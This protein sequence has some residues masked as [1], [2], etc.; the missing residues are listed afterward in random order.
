MEIRPH[1]TQLFG[2]LLVVIFVTVAAMVAAVFIAGQRPVVVVLPGTPNESPPPVLAAT[3]GPTAVASPVGATPPGPD[4]VAAPEPPT[5]RVSRLPAAPGIGNPF[6][7]A[8]DRVPTVELPLQPQQTAPPMLAT[9][10]IATVRVQAARDDRRIVWRLSWGQEEPAREV[11]VSTFSDA[12]AVQ[13]PMV[14]GAPFTMGGPGMPVRVL[15]WRA[16]WQQDLDA[17]FQDV[18]SRHPNTWNDLYWFAEGPP[19]HHFPAAF[20]DERA[21]DWLVAYRAGNPMA[22]FER[23]HPVEELVAEGFGSLTHVHD[24][25]SQARGAWQAGRWTVVID[26]PFD[27][28]DPLIERLGASSA[29]VSLAVWD[30]GH[31]NTGGR[32]HWCN[33]VP[34]RIEP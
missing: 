6:D 7:P 23:D 4:S 17:G 27:P 24:T 14:D 29:A 15:Y 21:R 18:Y 9:A 1:S 10:T 30:G 31:G 32:K 8:W 20:G 25:P 28:T 3:P 12:I 2:T 5:I 11:D 13:F 33:W 26:R 22:D 34:L 19:P 16:L